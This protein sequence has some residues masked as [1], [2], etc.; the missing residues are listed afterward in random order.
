M[1]RGIKI[2]LISVMA[3]LMLSIGAFAED[4]ASNNEF[5]AWDPAPEVTPP[6]NKHPRVLF[7]EEDI[8]DIKENISAKENAYAFEALENYVNR[9]FTVP[10][11]ETKYKEITLNAIEAQA[12][13]YAVFKD[14]PELADAALEAGQKAIDGIDIIGYMNPGTTVSD[15]CRRWGRMM[16]VLA[17]VYD[18]CY[19]LLSEEQKITV[20]N[21][22][23][24]YGQYM[25][26]WVGT[27]EDGAPSGQ[28]VIVGHGCE[29]QLL[30]DMLSFAV[31]VYDERPDIWS[32]VGGRYYD[33]YVPARA[34]WT[35][36]HFTHNGTDYGLWR[37]YFDDYA[38][39]LVTG[40]DAGDP[41]SRAN[42][43]K[44]G[45][46]EIYFRRPDGT[47][48]RDGDIYSSTTPPYSYYSG[49]ADALLLEYA[50]TGDAY[51]KGEL[52][53][54]CFTREG[55]ELVYNMNANPVLFLIYNDTDITAKTAYS[56]PNSKY[57]ASPSGI[58]TARTGWTEGENASSVAA[59][60]KIGE[61]GF[62]NHQHLD[63]GHFQIYYKGLLAADSGN[64]RSYG[65]AEHYMYTSKTV[66]H[67]CMLVFDPDEYA[68][69]AEGAP[70]NDHYYS[71][72]SQTWV[73]R[74]AWV[75]DG[76]QTPPYSYGEIKTIDAFLENDMKQAA[77]LAQ[78]IDPENTQRPYYTYIKGDLT[79]SYSD[80]VSDY[81]RSFMFLDLK[82]EETPAALIVFDEITSSDAKFKKT[83]LLHGTEKP[84]VSGNK[85]VF[86]NTGTGNISDYGGRLELT[87]LLPKSENL[88]TDIV[89]GSEDGWG[90]VRRWAYNED[91]SDW[92]M[93][94]EQSYDEA[95]ASDADENNTYRIELSPK[96]PSEKNYFLNVMLVGEATGVSAEL[97]ETEDFYG[98]TVLDRAV[99]FALSGEEN[100]EFEASLSGSY[101]YTVCDMKPG[102]YK[103][104]DKNGDRSVCVS[105][106]GHVLSFTASGSVTAAWQSDSYTAPS[107]ADYEEDSGIYM[108]LG[109]AFAS[110]GDS[111]TLSGEDFEVDLKGFAESLG[112]TV[113]SSGDTFK[114]MDGIEVLA[115]VNGSSGLI[116]TKRGIKEP[117]NEL[118]LENG[119]CIMML[120]DLK[121]VLLGGG[122]YISFAN[123]FYA[124]R[125]SE[126]AE[127]YYAMGYLRSSGIK[128]NI[129]YAKPLDATLYCGVFKDGVLTFAKKLSE[130]ADGHYYAYLDTQAV[131]EGEVK[132]FPWGTSF[133]PF[134]GVITLDKLE[135]TGYEKMHA[136]GDTSLKTT[137][138]SGIRSSRNGEI[139]TVKKNTT[140]NSEENIY[141]YL[142]QSCTLGE[143][144][145]IHYSAYVKN[146]SSSGSGEQ[147]Q[148]R[149]R[150]NTDAE[151]SSSIFSGFLID[152]TPGSEYKLDCIVDLENSYVYLYTD[153]ELSDS[154]DISDWAE[155][156]G[157]TLQ[158]TGFHHYFISSSGIKGGAFEIYDPYAVVYSGDITRD[159]IIARFGKT[160]YQ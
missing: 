95:N 66:A 23:R 119:S 73:Y 32:Y 30:R 4:V 144:G 76:G 18:W 90:V 71:P 83:W 75:N 149:V 65:D 159:E 45:Y 2:I 20:P 131:S 157:G 128:L 101:R 85:A 145:Y 154:A 96:T 48:F 141:L 77:V 93:T 72:S 130:D 146:L 153:G 27:A 158:I 115:T 94:F 10:T 41:Y 21:R 64:Y 108:K 88:S 142:N 143:S 28:G 107:D 156:Y 136:L 155:T 42:I 82:D 9:S 79:N 40:M 8:S 19:D 140:D 58:M 118:R 61:Y 132:V 47:L 110:F 129:T 97:I 56:L 74:R 5:S 51:L 49:S 111:V 117:Q 3:V 52:L 86:E 98:T 80:K 54:Q 91:L 87:T 137:A 33:E 113:V 15:V 150:G 7:T 26:M 60:M 57:F 102:T 50:M 89:G 31:A 17:E 39:M 114:I 36:S 126:P 78:E 22:F 109:D 135:S 67:N 59:V 14:D 35:T 133:T 11:S 38:F 112:Y 151:N 120:S 55:D 24:E 100:T 46:T 37:R 12:F 81:N 134:A 122:E 125:F 16:N 104:T 92:E 105:K 25:E 116:L 29:A 123:T 53:K 6:A 68:D 34:F 147:T 63:S 1:K 103:V 121:N 139:L 127:P 13:Y 124:S 152:N 84:S 99:F 70:T 44:T 62:N 160:I 106:D 138:S 69:A 43:S 148:F